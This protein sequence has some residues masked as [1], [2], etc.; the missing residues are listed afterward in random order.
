MK[1]TRRK[2]LIGSAM[3]PA[4]LQNAPAQDR[5]TSANDRIQ[6]GLIGAGGQG[7]DDVRSS[8]TAGSKL[9]AVADIY[10]GRL[11]RSKELWGNDLFTTRDYRELLARR[12]VDAV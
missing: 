6:V 3:A 7:M 8:L 10:E 2:L 1:T 9:V 5:P 4:F 11:T 12:D